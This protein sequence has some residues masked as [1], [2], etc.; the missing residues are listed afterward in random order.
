MTGMI[1]LRTNNNP[2]KPARQS[3]KALSCHSDSSQKISRDTPK[4]KNYVFIARACGHEYLIICARVFIMLP[5]FIIVVN[6]I[7]YSCSSR[8]VH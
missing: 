4:A 1:K 2:I 5:N 6:E 3:S 7:P 8:C